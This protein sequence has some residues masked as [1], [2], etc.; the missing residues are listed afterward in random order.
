MAWEVSFQCT[1]GGA[2]QL[3]LCVQD[4]NGEQQKCWWAVEL[5]PW[6]QVQA[7]VGRSRAVFQPAVGTLGPGESMPMLLSPSTAGG[8]VPW[9]SGEVQAGEG[10]ALSLWL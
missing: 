3:R 5:R 7:P 4:E 8:C 10:R 9:A 1:A 2:G 6:E